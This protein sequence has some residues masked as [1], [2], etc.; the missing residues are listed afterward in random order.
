LQQMLEFNSE[1]KEPLP[2]HEVIRATRSAEKAWKAK[3][4]AKANAE[5]ISRGYPGAGYNLK[6]T[7]IIEW[8]DITPE[9]QQHLSTIIDGREKRRRK[10]E[11]DKQRI[12]EIRRE[13][14]VKPREEY[15]E[16]QR[17]KTE[18]RVWQL[19]KA[20]ELHPNAT[21]KQL[22]EM[23]QLSVRRI[24]QLKKMITN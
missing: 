20:V 12:M 7:T 4:D 22:A 8:L 5:A 24:Q 18:D 19:K 1:F 23:L 14:G 21:N 17:E 2:E 11:R 15:L 10:R 6:N 9:E 16:E 3:S 13:Q